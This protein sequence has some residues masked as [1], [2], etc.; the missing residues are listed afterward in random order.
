MT[1]ARSMM[2]GSDSA[3]RGSMCEF[4]VDQ[5]AMEIGL[6]HIRPSLV[7]VQS[8]RSINLMRY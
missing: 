7:F 1:H 5:L 4:A 3:L 2:C 8:I 6:A